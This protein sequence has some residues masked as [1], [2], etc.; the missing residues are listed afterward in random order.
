[1]NVHSESDPVLKN[2]DSH[3]QITRGVKIA[4]LLL[5]SIWIGSVGI[6]TRSL[7]NRAERLQQMAADP[8][9]LNLTAVADE[10]HG[11]RQEFIILHGELAP[12]LWLG[13]HLGGDPGAAGPLMEA[14]VESLVAA[15]ESLSALTPSLGGL[16]LS[17]FSMEQMPQILE[18]RKSVV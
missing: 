15:D 3:Q 12:L 16:G 2:L 1:M 18:D 4:L 8:A 7:L 11:A 5:I 13:A 17:S 6:L 9:R 10:V 14:G